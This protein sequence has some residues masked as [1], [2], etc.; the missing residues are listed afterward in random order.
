MDYAFLSE[1]RAREL[2]RVLEVLPTGGKLLE[3]GAG[4]GWQAKA[5]SDAGFE[6]TAI[7]IESGG[8]EEQRVWPVKSYD[9][10]KIP[11]PDSSFDIVFS[12]NVLEHIPH[13]EEF[14]SE[15]RRVLRPQGRAVH[16]LPT[17]TWRFW[18]SLAHYAFLGRLG[19]AILHR[20][21]KDPLEG[22]I[23]RARRRSLR[24]KLRRAL[25][26]AR[27]GEVGN[28]VSELYLFSRLRWRPLFERTGWKLDEV[29]PVGLFY[30]GYMVAG[31]SCGIRTRQLLSRA[32]GSSGLI[33]VL[34][35][36]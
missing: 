15:I 1:I 3:I 34:R 5:L 10:V 7:D 33:Y 13:G 31:P 17:A 30:T 29:Y 21:D 25:F 9:G 28:T 16:V 4:A 20:S 12:S 18:T 6:V 19:V 24:Q 26:P 35:K 36:R 32:L 2:Q 22:A 14:Q 8:Y 11:F 27:H 23:K